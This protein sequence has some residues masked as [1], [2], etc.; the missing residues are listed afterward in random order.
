MPLVRK[1]IKVGNS[2]PVIIP[3]D[4]LKYYEQEAGKP[5]NNILMELNNVITISVGK[6]QEQTAVRPKRVRGQR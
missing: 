1:L 4:W 6:T 2:R 5:I 3:P